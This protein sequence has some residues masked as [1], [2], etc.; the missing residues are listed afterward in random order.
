MMDSADQDITLQTTGILTCGLI[1]KGRSDSASTPISMNPILYGPPN[2]PAGA[3]TAGTQYSS[4]LPYGMSDFDTQ[5][6]LPGYGYSIPYGALVFL[7]LNDMSTNT[8]LTGKTY[9]LTFPADWGMQLYLK[10]VGSAQGSTVIPGFGLYGLSS[11][12]SGY[13]YVTPEPSWTG[14]F[15]I[16]V[17]TPSCFSP[18]TLSVHYENH[19]DYGDGYGQQSRLTF[20]MEGAIGFVGVYPMNGQGPSFDISKRPTNELCTNSDA[21]RIVVP[22]AG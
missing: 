21:H 17:R 8:I 3:W 22:D 2:A 15:Q 1:K 6:T 10:V 18:E 11:N 9:T 5:V 12:P 4:V 7:F 19:K 13:T 20:T 14:D 16:S